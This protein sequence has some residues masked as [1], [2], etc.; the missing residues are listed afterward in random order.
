MLALAEVWAEPEPL[1]VE[2]SLFLEHSNA[3]RELMVQ[4]EAK[5]ASVVFPH[6]IFCDAI[7]CS[8]TKDGQ[9]L[10]TDR[11]H[12]SIEAARMIIAKILPFLRP[13]EE[14]K[15]DA[16]NSGTRVGDDG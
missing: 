9:M 13:D 8:V 1:G 7:T 15:S 2:T 10:Y 5:K 14:G 6:T 4:A 16:V 12:P 11:H 3:M